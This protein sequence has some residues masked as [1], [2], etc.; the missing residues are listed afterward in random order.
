MDYQDP[1]D[2]KVDLIYY[3]DPEGSSCWGILKLNLAGL[4]ITTEFTSY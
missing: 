1:K 3:T 4:Q 2:I